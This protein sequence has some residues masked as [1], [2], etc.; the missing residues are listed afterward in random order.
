[1]QTIDTLK[2]TMKQI[3]YIYSVPVT[4]QF[5]NKVIFQIFYVNGVMVFSRKYDLLP[6]F[7]F[8]IF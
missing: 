4:M 5:H 1:M 2:I 6:C 7:I 8:L 3:F